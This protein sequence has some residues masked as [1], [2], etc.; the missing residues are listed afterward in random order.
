MIV[1]AQSPHYRKKRFMVITTFETNQA[2]LTVRKTAAF[3][4]AQA[5]LDSTLPKLEI[6][7]RLN[8]VRLIQPKIDKKSL[9]FDWAE[10]K[11]L[12][13]QFEKAL[14]NKDEGGMITAIERALALL[15]Q[16]TVTMHNF[17]SDKAYRAIFG[18]AYNNQLPALEVGY[19][20]FNL[21]NFIFK[22]KSLTLIDYEWVFDFPLPLDYVLNRI[23]F[24]LAGEYSHIFA[25]FCTEERPLVAF[26]DKFFLP[27]VIVDHFQVTKEKL[28]PTLVSE[29][30]FQ[31]HVGQGRP[32]VIELYKQPRLITKRSETGL[33]EIYEFTELWREGNLSHRQSELKDMVEEQRSYIRR[34]EDELT[35]IKNTKLWRART[36]VKRI[37][38]P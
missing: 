37:V 31:A 34:L 24:N 26:A 15:Q 11:T 4:E 7:K 28:A 23:F 10:G 6:L 36:K 33:K 19:L 9:V 1:Y 12:A 14:L 22:N 8:G 13:S 32:R 29:Q 21:D 20:D 25:S 3:P 17:S 18:G 2:K 30:R 5:H 27:K 35:H 16:Q 38:K